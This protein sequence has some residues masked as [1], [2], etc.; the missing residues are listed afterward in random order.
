MKTPTNRPLPRPTRRQ[1]QA[2]LSGVLLV[3][4]VG[5]PA[6]ASFHGLTQAGIGALGLRDGWELLVPLV[7]DAGAAYTAVLA[8]RD[9]L[10]GDSAFLNRAL[11]WLYAVGGAGLNAWWGQTLNTAA[12]LYFGGATLSAVVLWDRTLRAMRR[13]QLR[14]RGAVQDPTPH[15]RPARWLVAPGETAHAWRAAVLEGVSDPKVAVEL[16][17][18]KRTEQVDRGK[19][20]ELEGDRQPQLERGHG[21]A[22]HGENSSGLTHLSKAAAIRHAMRELGSDGDAT[23][24]AAWLESRGVKVQTS[25]V[26][27]I[28]RRDSEKASGSMPPQVAAAPR[29]IAA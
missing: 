10:S 19:Q 23:S 1:V 7:L 12:A 14:E 5:A 2:G 29:Q 15:F 6:A 27:D 20:G 17:R 16:A 4:V 28:A 22:E 25:Y 11:T 9:V 26:C 13:D 8:L 24:V 21:E 3:A 18:A